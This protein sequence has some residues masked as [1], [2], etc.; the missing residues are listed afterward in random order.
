MRRYALVFMLVLLCVMPFTSAQD[1]EGLTIVASHSIL[2]DV[3]ANV[4]GDAA[5]VTSLMPI[6]ADPHTFV[7]T[8]RD[9]TAAADADVIF[10]NGAFFEEGLLET[11]EN[12]G[13]DMNIVTASECVRILPYGATA[14]DHDHE[15]GEDHEHE[16][17][18]EH[19]EGEDHE[20]EA[21]EM[22]EGEMSAIAE[23]CAAHYAEMDAIHEAGEEHAEA[24]DHEHEEGEE[25]AEGEE[26]GHSHS[27]V[28]TLDALYALE[29]GEGHEDGESEEHEEHE[30]GEEH[31]HAEGSCDP[32]VWM[33]PHNAMYWAMHIRD[34]L[35]EL[36]PANAETYTANAA[37]YLEILDALAHDF[38]MPMVETVPEE[39]RILV[40]NH[41]SL[42][43]FAARFGFELIGTVIP[44][45]GTAA[46][47]SAADIAAL[48]DLINEEGVP[49]I[50]TE[51]TVNDAVAQQI[52]DETGAQIALL[53]SG[54]LSEAGGPAGTY[55]DYI[56]YNVSTIVEALGGSTELSQ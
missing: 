45:G 7:P 33:E 12:L 2:A 32:H 34:T 38:V 37:A 8:P 36:D 11:I 21:E 25:H 1:G 41:D 14:H 44:G 22:T 49:A 53:Y 13:D 17:G 31:D 55:V 40:T 39:N 16:E 35:I 43:Y 10:I 3:I 47:P 24:E 15:D 28:E 54:S 48:I 4:A 52:A 23:R 50:F 26:H 29:C 46:E 9:L 30:E 6:G 20:H 19:A 5:E 56:R 51:T 18:E 27:E 42:G